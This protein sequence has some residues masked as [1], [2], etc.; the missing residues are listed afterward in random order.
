MHIGYKFRIYPTQDQ[1]ICLKKIL[2]C[3]RYIYNWA[4][5]K[6]R[7]AWVNSKQSVSYNKTS[8]EMTQLRKAPETKWL[9]EVP[10]VP[11]QQSLR[12]LD[13]AFVRF[14]K[15][16]SQ[17]PSFKARKNGGCAEYLDNAFR[18]KGDGLYLAK[19]KGSIRVNWS[20]KAN[21][22]P[23]KCSI[24]RNASGQWFASFLCEE[25]I[26]KLPPSDKRIGIDVG[27]EHFA[28]LSDG[29]K[30]S[31][32]K[33]I[34]QLRKKLAR[35]QRRHSRKAKGSKNRERARKKV[36]RLHQHIADVRKDF[37]HKLSTQLI[38][39]NQAI[40]IEDLAIISMVQNRKLSRVIS[41]QGWRD[42]RTMLEYKAEWYGRKILVVDRFFPSSKTCSCCGAKAA[43][44]LKDRVWSC[45]CGATHDR[46]VNAAKNIL[47][48]GLAV[49]AC[50]EGVRPTEKIS[51]GKPL[52]S[53]KLKSRDLS[54][55][56]SKA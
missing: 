23:S 8:A 4:L 10:Y 20:R 37:L 13:S 47:A 50:G 55:T 35:L 12:N 48:A 6:K 46:D 36:A 7:D 53:R 14:F 15:K 2:G 56:V 22:I 33:K 51:R 28:T 32:P 1:E 52:R 43:L 27:I 25:E 42:F 9:S 38:R 26:T 5:A 17:F 16:K 3:C 41:E 31:Q 11:V 18:I 29:R 44:T 39:E 19:I 30:F 49:S 34:R 40:A 24:S 54:L 45:A 21:S